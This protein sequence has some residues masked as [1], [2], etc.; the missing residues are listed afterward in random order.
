MEEVRPVPTEEI[1]SVLIT[2]RTIIRTRNLSYSTEKTYLHWVKRYL[3]FCRQQNRPKEAHISVEAFLSYLSVD[4]LSSKSTQAIALNAVVF[5]FKHLFHVSLDDLQFSLARKPRRLPQVFS[6]NEARSVLSH[7]HG[8]YRLTGALLYGAGLR[9]AE[10]LNLRIKDIDFEM[11]TIMVRQG[12]GDKDRLTLLPKNCLVALNKQIGYAKVLHAQDR[13]VN[14]PGVYLPNALEKKYPNAGI[15]FA[16][17]W[18]FPSQGLSIDPRS[19][20]K[21]RHHMHPSGM[22]KALNIALKS[23][24]IQKHAT[25]HTFR[26]SFATTLL[27]KGYDIRTIQELLGHKDVSTTE[28]YTHVIGKGAKGIIGPLDD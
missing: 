3:L 24:G 13:S 19:G 2:L 23:A 1:D 6:D 4:R 20:T 25:C 8:I 7:L 22:Q 9:K 10:C 15:S 17:F 27:R 12:K 21:R 16:W 5:V 28:I 14:L 26:H 18:L 11:S